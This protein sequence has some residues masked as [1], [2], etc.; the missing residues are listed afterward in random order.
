MRIRPVLLTTKLIP[1]SLLLHSLTVPPV[2]G[3]AVP[4][5]PNQDKLQ[6]D[7]KD[8]ARIYYSSQALSMV[9]SNLGGTPLGSIELTGWR[10]VME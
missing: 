2:P 3:V 7:I 8:N 4:L 9:Y 5:G 10:E 1:A 6:F